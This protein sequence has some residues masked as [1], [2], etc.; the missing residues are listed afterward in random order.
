MHPDGRWQE[1]LST[2]QR[3]LS[4]L[5]ELSMRQQQLASEQRQL[6]EEN[7]DEFG[8]IRSHLGLEDIIRLQG[9]ANMVP[10]QGQL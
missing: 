5:R 10:S 3:T 7:L 8:R 1:Q 4:Q 9:S 2:H 6:M